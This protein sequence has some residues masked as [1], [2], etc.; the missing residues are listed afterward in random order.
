MHYIIQ[1]HV[2]IYLSKQKKVSM[3]TKELIQ[4]EAKKLYTD[5]LK[6]L[7]ERVDNS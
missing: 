5:T 1:F 4:S 6:I 7:V 2:A 3:N